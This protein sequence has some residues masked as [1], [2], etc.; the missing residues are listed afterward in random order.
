MRDSDEPAFVE[1]V[2]TRSTALLRFACL[3][4]GNVADAEDLLQT[5]LVRLAGRWSTEIRDPNAY[6]KRSLVNLASS[7]WRSRRRREHLESLE[8]PRSVPDHAAAQAESDALVRALRQLP[9][10][11]RLIVVLRYVEGLS[12]REA[13]QLAD[14][15]VGTVKSQASRGLAALRTLLADPEAVPSERTNP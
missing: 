12:E 11:Q 13:A 3:L 9:A 7:R 10:R 4:T 5:A 6:V 1:F 8:R 2:A 15:S 14:C